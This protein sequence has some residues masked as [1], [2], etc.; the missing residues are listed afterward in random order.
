MGISGRNQQLITRDVVDLVPLKLDRKQIPC[1][2]R[3]CFY[4]Y[5][6]YQY[7]LFLLA[8]MYLCVLRSF[9]NDTNKL[10]NT[11]NLCL[12]SYYIASG[13]DYCLMM[14]GVANFFLMNHA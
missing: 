10:D 8:I 7:V 1:W 2:V 6:Y 11:K 9:E 12:N 4:F 5:K 13:I 3:F 14:F